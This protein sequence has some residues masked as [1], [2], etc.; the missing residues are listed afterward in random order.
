MSIFEYGDYRS[1]LRAHIRALP[2][3]GRGEL[4][5]IAKHLGMNTTLLSQIMSGSRDFN[6]EQT[7]SLSLYLGH[8]E[9]EMD[10]FSLLVQIERAGTSEL[11]EHLKKKLN[12][13]KSESLKLSKRII[14]EKKLSDQ[15]RAVFYSSWAYSAVHIFT[16]LSDKGVTLDEISRRFS[17]SKVKAAEIVQFLLSSEIII[18]KSGRYRPGVQ[19]TFVE[20]GSP[21]LLKHHSSWR[22][23]AIQKSENLSDNELMITGQYSLSKKD[24]LSLRERL[25]EFVKVLN[26]AVK[27]TDPE[28]IVC[29]NLDWFWLDK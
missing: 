24:F 14:Y 29:L 1:Y 12:A 10:F 18:E 23:K 19:S 6:H 28:E 7:Y 9:L 27:E 8:M 25:T 21:H 16:S 26:M 11:K 20:Q 2:R 22:V 13:I 3:K 5:N 15:E 17:F 4:S